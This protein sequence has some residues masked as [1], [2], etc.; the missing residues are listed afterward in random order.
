MSFFEYASLVLK[1]V[2]HIVYVIIFVIFIVGTFI[3][4]GFCGYKK[5]LRY[6][7]LLMLLE[8]IFLVYGSTVF[9]RNVPKARTFEFIPFWSYDKPEL[10]ADN[11]MN[12]TIFIPIGLLAGAAFRSTTWKKVMAYGLC[13]S[14][15]IEVM[16]YV[17]KKG[18]SE[19]DDVIHNTLG[20]LIG[21]IIYKIMAGIT[22]CLLHAKL[23]II[24]F[25]VS[26][27][28]QN[29]INCLAEAYQRISTVSSIIISPKRPF[30]EQ[31]AHSNTTY[32]IL[33]PIELNGE[34]IT[35]P[36]SSVLVFKE[37]GL[38]SNG[39]L[40]GEFTIQA[41]SRKI[42]DGVDISSIKCPI[43]ISWVLGK[44]TELYNDDFKCLPC[45]QVDFEN[46]HFVAKEVI[47]LDH[48]DGFFFTNLDIETEYGMHYWQPQIASG[49]CFPAG[50]AKSYNGQ[51]V[52]AKALPNDYVGYMIDITTSDET[53]YDS[54]PDNHGVP[55]LYKGITSRIKQIEG[56]VISLTDSIELFSKER[57]YNGHIVESKFK[58]FKPRTFVLS[59]CRFSFTNKTGISLRGNDFII[60]NSFFESSDGSNTILSLGGHNGTVRNCTVRGAYYSGT[61]TSYGIQVVNGTRITIENCDFY[62]NRRSVDFSGGHESRYN[63]VKNCN[64]YQEKNVGKT[65]SAIGG[66][67]TS[68]GNVFHNN[69]IYGDYQ[70]G[71]QC[72]GENEIID[73][74]TFNCT[75]ATMIS[76][77]YN[78]LIINNK[79][80][81]LSK[82]AV[83]VF[84]G[85]G[86]Q[87][88][89][90]TLRVYNNDIEIKRLLI[91]GDKDIKYYVDNNTIRFRPNASSVEPI[92]FSHKPQFYELNN[93]SISC[94]RSDTSIKLYTNGNL[95]KYSNIHEVSPAFSRP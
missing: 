12:I 32:E 57:E 45:Y 83:G 31:V 56:N 81:S 33:Y 92:V 59:N 50:D 19:L 84:A 66:H 68:F 89:G 73:G 63:E 1:N 76:F 2:P 23:V 69:T 61:H 40:Y 53:K 91:N 22:K 55:T 67:S 78:T 65:G 60:E 26:L 85:S 47:S 44:R 29:P 43:K 82:K 52:V 7:S 10:I 8:Y 86:I 27:C 11:M 87:V 13:L 77:S 34:T 62:E 36:D 94:S 79:V 74:N 80:N 95:L 64:F 35:V 4:I 15:G 3:I 93:N 42:F 48:L 30:S 38:L 24:V 6:V 70:V 28:L 17:F 41:P 75:A 71:I 16:Q 39:R 25:A 58:V 37:D 51:I 72:R 14:V 9:F 88:D 46:I 90:N 18:L 5:G 21:Y 49:L 20:C 54:R